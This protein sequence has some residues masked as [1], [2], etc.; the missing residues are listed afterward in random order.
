MTPPTRTTT[1]VAWAILLGSWHRTHHSFEKRGTDKTNLK[2]S[3][4]SGTSA[5]CIDQEQTLHSL[6]LWILSSH[7]LT[8]QHKKNRSTLTLNFM[9]QLTRNLTLEHRNRLSTSWLT[10]LPKHDYASECSYC[11]HVYDD[12]EGCLS[13]WNLS[14]PVEDIPSPDNQWAHGVCAFS[15]DEPKTRGDLDP[16]S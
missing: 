13:L 11:G 7:K 10:V 3:N 4:S 6:V 2:L 1:S 5:E 8:W 14:Y 16:P 15:R 9:R 12:L